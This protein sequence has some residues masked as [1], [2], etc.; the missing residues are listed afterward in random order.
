MGYALLT[1]Q[2][3]TEGE[4]F[5][6]RAVEQ[7]RSGPVWYMRPWAEKP[8]AGEV[9]TEGLKDTLNTEPEGVSGNHG[10]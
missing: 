7:G 4:E 8:Q 1:E 3:T 2:Q 9:V 6:S 5:L 10:G